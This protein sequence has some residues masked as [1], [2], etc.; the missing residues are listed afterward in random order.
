MADFSI[1]SR[2]II[3][4]VIKEIVKSIAGFL[5]FFENSLLFP[6]LHL[7]SSLKCSERIEQKTPHSII[8]HKKE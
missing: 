1:T 2:K 4:Y 6:Y 8:D 7:H 3:E 5:I